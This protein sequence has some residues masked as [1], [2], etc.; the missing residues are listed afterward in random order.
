MERVL[1]IFELR[2][3]EQREEGQWGMVQMRGESAKDCRMVKLGEDMLRVEGGIGKLEGGVEKVDGRKVKHGGTLKR[4]LSCTGVGDEG[5]DKDVKR[6]RR[7]TDVSGWQCG[8]LIPRYPSTILL[9][10]DP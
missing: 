8:V 10:I 6:A 2:Y 4:S 3:R 5:S 7:W 1:E 9:L